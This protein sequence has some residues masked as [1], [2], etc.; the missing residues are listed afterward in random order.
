MVGRRGERGQV[1]PLVAV[2]LTALMGFSGMAVDHGYWQ[3]QQR[4][5]Q[6]AADGA[7]IG[8]AQ[9]L[10][11]AGCGANATAQT[12]AQ[13]D[14]A[15]N[16]FP[17]A[18]VT[19]NNPPTTGAYAG[20]TCA[21]QVSITA[22]HPTFF[23]N[24]LGFKQMKETTT[25]T[26][27]LVS[28]SNGTIYL[29]GNQTSNLNG[30][31]VTVPGTIMTNGTFTCGSNTISAAAIGYAG[32]APSCSKATFSSASPMPS[33]PITNPCPEIAGCNYLSNNPPPTTNCQTLKANMNPT[34]T[35]GCY[36]NL[37]VGGCG[38]VT[39]QPGV[40]V[41]NGTSD[42]S[43]SSFVGSGVTFYVTASGTPPDFSTAQSATITP[44]TSGNE[45]NVLYYQVPSNTK[46]PNFSGST[47]QWRGLVYAPT[48]TG[49]NFD[50]AK[51][52]YSVL[53]LGSAN[54]S[55]NTTYTFGAAPA[56]ATL[57]K[58]VVLGQ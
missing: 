42:F 1:I 44:P 4:Q 51:G 53:I 45:A 6:N 2:T 13:T 48:A 9:S 24:V 27:Q 52:D 28:N 47:V 5:Q 29:M 19:V 12:A 43:G 31:N 34:L 7:A 58:N 18:D 3:Y 11:L 50:G 41:L 46:A 36:N 33:V 35:A 32:A 55:D 21:V 38:T 22:N 37:T 39:L 26:A 14:A 56:G 40:Y 57:P 15:S 54:L 20:N 16:G 8:G 49:V 10:A 30:G 17:A 25:A 23:T